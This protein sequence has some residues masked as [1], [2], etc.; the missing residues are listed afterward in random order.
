MREAKANISMLYHNHITTVVSI[1][2]CLDH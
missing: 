1:S 2:K